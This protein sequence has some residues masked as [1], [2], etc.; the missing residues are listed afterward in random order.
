MY[1]DPEF[2]SRGLVLWEQ[3]LKVSRWK[4]EISTTAIF[5]EIFL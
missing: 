5:D 2:D 3:Y 4:S 1:K